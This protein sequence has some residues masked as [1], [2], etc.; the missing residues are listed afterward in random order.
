MKMTIASQ[1]HR[2]PD[3]KEIKIVADHPTEGIKNLKQR[4]AHTFPRHKIQYF[5]SYWIEPH[6]YCLKNLS[7]DCFC[8]KH[9][10]MFNWKNI[11]FSHT[12]SG[13]ITPNNFPFFTC[14]SWNRKIN[15]LRGGNKIFVT[16]ETIAKFQSPSYPSELLMHYSRFII[17]LILSSDLRRSMN[18]GAI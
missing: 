6:T 8:H 2:L 13:A 9:R 10:F 4:S 3:L 11:S 1:F 5:L 15:K 16:V 12:N 14:R 18:D 7:L 17:K